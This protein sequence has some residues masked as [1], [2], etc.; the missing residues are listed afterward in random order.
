MRKDLLLTQ[1]SIV[2]KGKAPEGEPPPGTDNLQGGQGVNQSG[3][4]I[5]EPEHNRPTQPDPSRTDVGIGS[6][7]Y[8]EPVSS[9]IQ[10]RLENVFVNP[11]TP[12]PEKH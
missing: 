10:K 7:T 3:G 9:S 12:R 8:P 11:F 6:R 1:S 2:D 4:S 5:A